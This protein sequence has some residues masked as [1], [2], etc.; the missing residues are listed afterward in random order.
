MNTVA[1]N[2]ARRMPRFILRINSQI[3]HRPLY[4]GDP[5]WPRKERWVARTSR[6]MT[7][8]FG[9]DQNKTV[10]RVVPT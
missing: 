5:S 6:A 8:L 10:L 9:S 1:Q 3:R 7:D 4:A 2:K